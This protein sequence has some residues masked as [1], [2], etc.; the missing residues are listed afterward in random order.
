[1]N[2]VPSIRFM[3]SEVFHSMLAWNHVTKAAAWFTS[4]QNRAD[5]AAPRAPTRSFRFGRLGAGGA[6]LVWELC[7]LLS[8]CYLHLDVLLVACGFGKSRDKMSF[9]YCIPE[10]MSTVVRLITETAAIPTPFLQRR[11]L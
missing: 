9:P 8:E 7:S 3:A 1:M 5:I 11:M 10:P 6:H 4:G 2:V